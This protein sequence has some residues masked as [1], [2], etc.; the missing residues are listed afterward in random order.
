MAAPLKSTA[1]LYHA[2][3]PDG[4]GAAFAAWK[5]FGEGADYIPVFHGKPVPDGLDGKEVFIADFSYPNGML[6]ELE[7]KVARLVVLDHHLGAKEEVIAVREHVFDEKRSGA[8]IAWDY[9]HPTT[10]RPHLI[11]YVEDGDLYTFTLPHARDVLAYVYTRPFTFESWESIRALLESEV[12]REKIIAEGASYQEHW[13]LLI[14]KIMNQAQLVEFEGYRVYL[15]SAP[16]MFASDTGNRLA[17]K[18]PPFALVVKAG[19]DGVSVSLRSDGSMNV[20]DI[21]KKYGGGGHPAAAGFRLPYGTPVPW[22][23]IES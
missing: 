16:D 19:V 4:F 10:P 13:N 6:V 9:F 11:N 8:G 7:K 18:Q 12:E 20:S 21:A 17:R 15:A 5:K 1:I 14:E 2:Q 23:I 3:C 22:N